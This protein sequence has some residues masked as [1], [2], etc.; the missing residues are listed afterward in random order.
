MDQNNNIYLISVLVSVVSLLGSIT[1][2]FINW[3]KLKP[4]K[5]KLDAEA[6]SEIAEAADSIVSGAKVSN[7]LL[8]TELRRME[9][10]ESEREQK[11]THLKSRFDALEAEF[12]LWKDYA[13]RLSHQVQSLGHEPVPFKAVKEESKQSLRA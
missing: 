6:H 4:E 8:M 12:I 7:E 11:Y 9:K 1:A 2:I 10:R 5:K 3:A 13:I